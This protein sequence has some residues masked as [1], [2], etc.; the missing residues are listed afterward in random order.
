[1]GGGLLWCAAGVRSRRERLGLVALIGFAVVI[2]AVAG[3]RALD[4]GRGLGTSFR[5]RAEGPARAP[6]LAYGRPARSSAVADPERRHLFHASRA[7]DGAPGTA[8]RSR[9][10]VDPWWE[11]DLGSERRV[12]RITLA[13]PPGGTGASSVEVVLADENGAEHTLVA[14]WRDETIALRV[15]PERITR[16]IRIE[17][18]GRTVLALADVVVEGAGPEVAR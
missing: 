16:R 1:L 5:W 18:R 15:T 13:R 14:R 4:G 7:V 3:S 12:G 6:D 10:D 17:A 11:V 8:F 9:A 2:A